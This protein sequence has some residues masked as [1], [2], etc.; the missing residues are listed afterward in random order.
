VNNPQSVYAL[1]ILNNQ[2]EYSPIEKKMTLLKP[3]KNTSLLTPY[4]Q[5]FIQEFHRYE[6]LVSERNPGEHNPL[7]QMVINPAHTPT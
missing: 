1:H 2:H 6:R 7:L 5:F 4:E 3:L